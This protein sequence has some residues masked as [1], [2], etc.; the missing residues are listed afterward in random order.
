MEWVE[1]HGN[2]SMFQNRIRMLFK[3]PRTIKL[4]NS[5]DAHSEPCQTCKM[6]FFARIVNG[7]QSLT[8]FPM[9]SILSDSFW[10]KFYPKLVELYF[11]RR[12]SLHYLH[13]HSVIMKESTKLNRKV[14]I[15]DVTHV[16]ISV[17]NCHGSYSDPT[18][19]SCKSTFKRHFHEC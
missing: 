8:V 7:S 1:H 6:D 14:G 17:K 16:A 15:L 4:D 12:E 9:L 19:E 10:T 11:Y 2:T 3:F 13:Y 18:K 5:L